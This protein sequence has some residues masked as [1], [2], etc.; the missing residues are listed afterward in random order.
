MVPCAQSGEHYHGEA[1]RD[2]RSTDGDNNECLFESSGC[3]SAAFLSEEERAPSR[4]SAVDGDGDDG[5]GFVFVLLTN[6]NQDSCGS[7]SAT[8]EDR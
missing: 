1:I 3:I 5:D 2:N 4:F 8:L 7:S 6:S